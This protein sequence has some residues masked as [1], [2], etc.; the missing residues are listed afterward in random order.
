LKVLAVLLLLSS[1]CLA[2]SSG[3][4]TGGG[5]GS[6]GVSSINSTAGAFTFTGSGVS[7]TGTTC[8]FSSGGSQAFS[9]LTSGINTTAAMVIGTGASFTFSGSGTINANEI[10]GTVLSGLATGPLYNTTGTGVPSIETAAQAISALGTNPVINGTNFVL[11]T[12]PVIGAT[13]PAAI[14]CTICTA[15]TSFQGSAYGAA[16]STT[17]VNYLGGQNGSNAST[18]GSAIVHGGNNASTGTG[19]NSTLQAGSSTSGQQ[20]FANVLQSFT[21][22]SALA[23]TFNVV[24]MT[25]TADQVAA[26]ALGSTTGIVGI[27]QTVGGTGTTLFVASNGKTTVRFDGTPVVG[28]TACAP[29]PATGTAG[30]AH[31]NGTT[32]CSTSSLVGV[33]TGQV[34]GTGSGATATVL[35]KLN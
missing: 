23:T 30:L 14:S 25:T 2:Q 34:S 18:L 31:D 32:A 21:T 8:T 10:N 26:A 19:G 33:V 4:N 27:A 20:G 35:L 28:D 7:C 3:G 17:T 1:Y 11:T 24:S 29:P 15:T 6:A 13:T 22:A 16:A 9:S 5:G 12:P